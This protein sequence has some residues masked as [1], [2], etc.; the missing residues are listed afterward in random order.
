MLKQ[1]KETFPKMSMRTINNYILRLE[2]GKKRSKLGHTILIDYSTA[3]LL[4]L[5][6]SMKQKTTEIKSNAPCNAII[7]ADAT[8]IKVLAGTQKK[9]QL[10]IH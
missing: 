5:T 3:T 2:E 7:P 8:P 4:T 9:Q 6:T 10:L 1:G